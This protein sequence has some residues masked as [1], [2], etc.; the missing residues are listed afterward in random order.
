LSSS[1]SPLSPLLLSNPGLVPL[2]VPVPVPHLCVWTGRA[3]RSSASPVRKIV[4]VAADAKQNVPKQRPS[5]LRMLRVCQQTE[6]RL[7]VCDLD[8]PL[9]DS[10]QGLR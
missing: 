9:K 7:Y 5:K 3:A 1:S 8:V 4:S 6:V 2:P 10:T